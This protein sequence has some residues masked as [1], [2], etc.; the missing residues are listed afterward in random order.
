M[1]QKTLHLPLEQYGAP[2]EIRKKGHLEPTLMKYA[3]VAA[4]INRLAVYSVNIRACL[5]N[6]KLHNKASYAKLRA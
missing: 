3:A 6:K 4:R 2:T 1:S 5:K